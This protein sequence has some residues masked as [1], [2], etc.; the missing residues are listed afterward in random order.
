MKRIAVLS[1]VMAGL[2]PAI[3]DFL[4]ERRRAGLERSRRG[5]RSASA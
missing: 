1:V 5:R 2:D 4:V 3:H